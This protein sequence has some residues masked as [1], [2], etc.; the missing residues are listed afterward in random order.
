MGRWKQISLVYYENNV[1]LDSDVVQHIADCPSYVEFEDNM[2]FQSVGFF[3]PNCV[4]EIQTSGKYTYQN[5]VLAILDDVG[6]E[7]KWAV[8]TL[9]EMALVLE[10][11]DTENGILIKEAAYFERLK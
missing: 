9:T 8:P 1:L 7:E 4:P 2:I 10:Q 5:N 3:T 11:T 6:D